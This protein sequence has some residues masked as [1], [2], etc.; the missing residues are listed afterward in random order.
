MEFIATIDWGAVL[1]AALAFAFA[2]LM[3]KALRRMSER[4][5]DSDG[6]IESG[7]TKSSRDHRSKRLERRI[8]AQKEAHRKRAEAKRRKSTTPSAEG[9]AKD[10]PPSEDEADKETDTE[11]IS[12]GLRKTRGGFVARLGGLFAGK[13]LDESLMDAVEE[14]LFTADIGVQAAEKL[15]EG[16]RAKLKRNELRDPTAVW[17]QLKED[18]LQMLRS[19]PAA[20]LQLQGHH[21]CVVLVIGVNG[22][23]KTTSIGKLASRY[24]QR[25]MKTILA[26]GDTFRAAAVDQLRVWA[27]RAQVPVVAGKEGADP[28]SVIVDAL[29]AASREKADLVIAD[30]AGRLHTKTELMDEL[31]KVH[32]AIGKRVA[33]APHETLLVVDATMGQ[34]AI[35]QAKLFTDAAPITGIIL[36]KL[37]GTA[38]GGVILGLC[39]ELR[40]PVRFVGVGE[41]I[42]DLREFDPASFVDALFGPP[43]DPQ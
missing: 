41:G 43:P 42:E 4:R 6:E 38:K 16:L 9:P 33:G 14:V 17:D 23:G 15:T 21:P 10:T 20:P 40:L 11:K 36:T 3:V 29:N 22:T 5:A 1:F 25:G 31:A 7:K 2:L 32:R 28:S 13:Q 19:V 18:S 34:N 26:A 35:A 37:D 12:A 39:D 8:K 24:S 27:Q 30:T